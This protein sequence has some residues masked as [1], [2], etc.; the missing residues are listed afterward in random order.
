MNY[1]EFYSM[2]LPYL[3]IRGNSM[4]FTQASISYNT[5]IAIQQ[6]YNEYRWAF[7]FKTI[8][9]NSFIQVGTKY[10]ATIV[11][12]VKYPVEVNY[13]DKSYNCE[14]ITETLTPSKSILDFNEWTFMYYN[15]EVT[16]HKDKEC[17][18]SY[19]QQYEFKD[20]LADTWVELPIPT[21]F[22]PAL[23]YL[24]LSQIDPIYVQQAEGQIYNH[25]NKYQLEINKLKQDEVPVAVSFYWAN[26]K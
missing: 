4:L 15:K 24:V 10:K 9:L 3:N 18:F 25:Y 22:I 7:Q 19:F 20:Y 12:S 21:S 26:P 8:I 1:S 6:I 23:Y 17:Y 5:N 16:V 2:L 11:D 13:K 14:N